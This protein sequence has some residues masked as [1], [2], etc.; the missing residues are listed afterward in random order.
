MFYKNFFDESVSAKPGTLTNLK[1][2]FTHR[3]V[4]T[5]KAYFGFC[6]CFV[7]CVYYKATHDASHYYA[8]YD[9]LKVPIKLSFNMICCHGFQ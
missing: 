3:Q 4:L 2:V 7:H 5:A 1:S 8:S 9:L 6:V